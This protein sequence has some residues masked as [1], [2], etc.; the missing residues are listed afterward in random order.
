MKRNGGETVEVVE[1]RIFW[2]LPGRVRPVVPFHFVH[3]A[4]F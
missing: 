3:C 4:R 2:P 1:K